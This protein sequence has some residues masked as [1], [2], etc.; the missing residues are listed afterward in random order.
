[1][2]LGS[3]LGAT[4]LIALIVLLEWSRIKKVPAKDK[5]AFFILLSIGWGL[6]L[7][8]LTELSGPVTW[9]T[10]LFEPIMK[11]ILNLE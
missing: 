8:D 11:P 3:F 5:W 7:F 2:R 6:T 10:S 4:I 1:M 9:T